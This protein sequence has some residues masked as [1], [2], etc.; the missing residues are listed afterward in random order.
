MLYRRWDYSSDSLWRV[1]FPFASALPK[2]PSSC[3]CL[4]GHSTFCAG[5]LFRLL[6]AFC[7][8]ACTW[9]PSTEAEHS[10]FRGALIDTLAIM[11]V[12]GLITGRKINQLRRTLGKAD[13]AFEA[14]S[15][16][17]N[18]ELVTLSYGLRSGLAFGIVFLMTAK[19]SLL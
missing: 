12:G 5:F 15:A 9:P 11:F 17:A 4:F 6:A 18:D 2:M 14:L 8:A 3:N 16:R 1:L 19:P 13:A 10:G 7:W